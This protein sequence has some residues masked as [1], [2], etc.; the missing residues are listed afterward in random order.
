MSV[1]RPLGITILAALMMIFG[2]VMFLIG[3]FITVVSPMIHEMLG[4]GF[5]FSYMQMLFMVIGPILVIS[6]LISFVLGFGLWKGK[7]WARILTI[8]FNVIS[9]IFNIFSLPQGIIGLVINIIIIYYL[10]REN[11]K[12][13]FI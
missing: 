5:M 4:R 3:L 13:Y 9:L 11:V 7:N 2:I 10:T 12:Q 6:G 8:I 1:E